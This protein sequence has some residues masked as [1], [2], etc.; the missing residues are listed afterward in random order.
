MNLEISFEEAKL[1]TT[2]LIPQAIYLG[3]LPNQ[4][5]NRPLDAIFKGI[6][7]EN[8]KNEKAGLD[9]GGGIRTRYVSGSNNSDR[10]T[11]FIVIR[12]TKKESEY[13]NQFNAET[14][15]LTY[16]GDN[17]RNRDPLNTPKKGNRNLKRIFDYLFDKSLPYEKYICPILYFESVT[18]G[19]TEQKFVGLAYPY[20]EG[21][22]YGE[23]VSLY[24][25]D[26]V[27]NYKFK[28]TIVSERISKAWLY[29]L[30][31]GNK[32]ISNIAP[33]S[34]NKFYN[35]YILQDNLNYNYFFIEETTENY[36][37]YT[38]EKNLK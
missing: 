2:D 29:E 33:N 37:V 5:G 25:I 24:G 30:L 21:V 14:S 36:H 13:P 20:V 7:D 22:S 35:N 3:K 34:W 26:G 38:G 8:N 31:I 15:V 17:I 16:Y 12:N 1:S 10:V 9:G 4:H 32:G 28:F 19:S 27:S 11:G 23:L 18:P 6:V